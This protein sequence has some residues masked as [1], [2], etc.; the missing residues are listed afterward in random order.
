MPPP[1]THHAEESRVKAEQTLADVGE[2]RAVAMKSD[3]AGNTESAGQNA[4]T[5]FGVVPTGPRAAIEAALDR[6]KVY[7]R[8]ARERG[9]QGVVHVRF[10]LRPSGDV[11]RVEIAKSS[12]YAIL[13]SASIK[14]VYRASPMPYVNGWME[15]FMPYVLK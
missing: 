8:L 3:T 7:P 2:G 14:T 15:V 13:D 12:G 5:Q 6:A 9:I 11:E 4:G 1:E 10:K